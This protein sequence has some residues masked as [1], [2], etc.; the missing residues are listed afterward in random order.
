MEICELAVD[1]HH[2]M[3][4]KA[5]SWALR[6]VSKRNKKT[7]EEFIKKH[8]SRWSKRVLREVK[9]KLEKGTKYYFLKYLIMKSLRLLIILFIMNIPALIYSQHSKFNIYVA[10]AYEIPYGD[11]RTPDIYPEK[12]NANDGA[13]FT[14]GSQ[15]EAY[16]K[17]FMGVESAYYKF[18]PREKV[19][20]YEV[21]QSIFSFVINSTYYF[22]QS[23]FRPYFTLGAGI[24]ATAL[25][26]QTDFFEE[27]S[28]E[29]IPFINIALGS[30]M[31]ITEHTALFGFIRWSD[32]LIK[33][34]NFEYEH[35]Q[36]LKP[37]FNA[38]FLGFGAGIKYWF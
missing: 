31:L 3:I 23:D 19:A 9:H 22:Q 35:F 8:E 12:G 7:V 38:N 20:N 36:T 21:Y 17:L 33:R 5:L 28:A 30:D 4:S 25:N 37:E 15:I 10:G 11:F 34:K 6:D 29:T 32:S 13:S 26:V 24:S 1:D 14:L 27:S 18:G 16:D 2:E